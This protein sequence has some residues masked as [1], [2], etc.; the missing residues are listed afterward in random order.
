LI[1]LAIVAATIMI[2]LFGLARF[3]AFR[4]LH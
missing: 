1:K 4:S 3:G 2:G